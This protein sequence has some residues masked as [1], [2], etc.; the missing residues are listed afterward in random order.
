MRRIRKYR[1]THASHTVKP[2]AYIFI[3]DLRQ[4]DKRGG[5]DILG[6]YKRST[7][8]VR[9]RRD[10]RYLRNE[11]ELIFSNIPLHSELLPN[12]QITLYISLELSMK[13]VDVYKE[14]QKERAYTLDGVI[15][16]GGGG[17]LY[18]E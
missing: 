12:Y 11:L 16:G 9:E 4:A 13:Y 10:K 8:N 15:S 18:P 6:A 7:R 2:W 3:R 5:G 14:T 17:G 1:N